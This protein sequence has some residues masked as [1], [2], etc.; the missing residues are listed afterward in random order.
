[1]FILKIGQKITPAKLI[2]Q[3]ANLEYEYNTEAND[4]GL[5][6]FRG[7]VA[8]F[9]SPQFKYPTRIDF[10][11]DRIKEI[12][13]FDEYHQ[14]QIEIMA[15]V[16]ILSA[17]LPLRLKK[18]K[19]IDIS[20]IASLAPGDLIVH[21]DHGI[22]QF[23]GLIFKSIEKIKREYI[24]LRYGGGDTLYLPVDLADKID[25]YIGPRPGILHKLDRAAWE[26]IKSKTREDVALFA[27]ELL[28]VYSQRSLSA[29]NSFVSDFNLEKQ[30]A[31]SFMY[32][33]TEDQK[34]AI[35]EVLTDLEKI[36]P[37]DRLIAGDVGFG[38]TEVAVRAAFRV[39]LNK[40]QVA[41]LCPTTILAQQHFDTFSERFNKMK[42]VSISDFN[43]PRISLLSRFQSSNR[44]KDIVQKICSGE[45][46]IV[47]ATHRILSSDI[48]FKNL[49]LLIIDEEQKF[50]VA[51]K[52]KLK[53]MK[54]QIHVL[55]LSA[56]P[57]PRSLN[58][59]LTKL[60][61]I[62]LINT[63]PLGRLPVKT[64]VATYNPNL[65][66]TAIINEI[67][68]G[69]QVYYLFN[70]V[71]AMEI[72]KREIENLL[73]DLKNL[74]GHS[75]SIKTAH[76]QMPAKE[77]AQTMHQFDQGKIDV[78]LCS[79]IIENG[80]D[81][82]NVN[83]LIVEKAEDLGLAQAY[84]LRGRIGRGIKQAYAYFFYNDY[85][86]KMPLP[87]LA[88]SCAME[89]K[90]IF[91]Q[92]EPDKKNKALERLEAIKDFADLGSGFRI[93]M[94]DLEIRGA[95]AIL[96]KKQHGPIGA[97]GLGLYLTMLNQ[98]VEKL[99]GQFSTQC[100]CQENQEVNIDLPIEY[101]LPLSIEPN[102]V[103]R[104][105]LYHN[106]AKIKNLKE[107]ERKFKELFSRVS[108]GD[109][110]LKRLFDIFK[111]KILAKK[112]DIKRIAYNYQRFQDN[113]NQNQTNNS[114]DNFKII[115]KFRNQQFPDSLLALIEKNPFWQ[116]G[117]E[118]I[119]ISANNLGT[120][121]ILGLI[122]SL[123]MLN[124]NKH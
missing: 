1:M 44:Q 75:I 30:L 17:H 85:K 83:T 113:Y 34:K 103:K 77:L 107:L 68:K 69:G 120:N 101:G 63:P 38:K 91:R 48:K 59:S 14:R 39:F 9:W 102:E 18:T 67:K 88:S 98:E 21:L 96:G 84:Q 29:V 19:K 41:L 78:L 56:T 12:Y 111:I 42:Q 87:P 60:R 2:N 15:E 53:K 72:K 55:T 25:K 110:F 122:K 57:I 32:E 26:Q 62:S 94:R 33:E 112:L 4:P 115:V 43:L 27:N 124:S 79:T 50:G 70:K 99:K 100:E 31:D 40:A 90:L 7:D 92:S 8:D 35:Y 86:V 93:A 28:A 54:P 82:P 119:K 51:A 10:D 5:Y 105:E 22:G 6:S 73:E 16:K 20:F 76:G 109:K 47:I 61:D 66:K 123:E 52:E 108:G 49:G 89:R 104:I 24:I 46:D 71:Q 23:L 114:C 58:L 95:G 74:E 65:I 116:V 45:I 97:V 121:W 11:F 36:R 117:N 3:L 81:L 13:L 64:M 106:L 118:T 80:L 37:M